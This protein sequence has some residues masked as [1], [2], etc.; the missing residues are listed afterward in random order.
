MATNWHIYAESQFPWE[1]SALNYVR[2]RLPSHS[3]WQAWSNF[4]FV[5]DDGKLYE[6]DLMVFSP[7]GWFLIEIKSWPGVLRGDEP[8]DWRLRRESGEERSVD[9][10]L[11]LLNTKAKKLKSLLE[12]RRTPSERAKP[13][14]FL[15][16]LVFLSHDNLTSQLSPRAGAGV[17]LRNNVMSALSNRSTPGLTPNPDRSCNKPGLKLVSKLLQKA[18]VR[19]SASHRKVG[20]YELKQLLREGPGWQDFALS[21]PK[22]KGGKPR[23]ARVYN[24]IQEEDTQVRERLE[25]AA[26]REFRLLDGF[27]HPGVQRLVD[28]SHQGELGPALIFEH[29]PDATTL[30]DWWRR[31]AS[32]AGGLTDELRLDVLRQLAEAVQYAHGRQ[33][34]HRSLS[35]YSVL[36]QESRSGTPRTVIRDWQTGSRRSASASMTRSAGGTLAPTL[37]AV[38]LSEDLA[39]AYLAPELAIE[40]NRADPALEGQGVAQDIFALGAI[41]FELFAGE[42]PA[43]SHD[44][45]IRRLQEHRGLSVAAVKDGVPS[46]IEEL[47]SLAT[48]PAISSRY[49][50][51]DGFL[52]Q[53]NAIEEHL[54]QPDNAWDGPPGEAPPDSYLSPHGLRVL[55]RLG[56]GSNAI[57]LLV[58]RDGGVKGSKNEEFVLKVAR[59]ADRKHNDRI[60]AETEVLGAL[61]SPYFVR[62]RE[63]M[64]LGGYHAV[65][66]DRAGERS[67]LEDIRRGAFSPDQLQILGTDLIAALAALEDAG[68]AHRDIKPENIGVGSTGPLRRRQLVLYDF[69]LSR[70][71]PL[72]LKAGTPGFIDPFLKQRPNP[73]WDLHAER[74]AAAVTLYQMATGGAFPSWGDGSLPELLPADVVAPTLQTD[75]FDPS[76]RD[77]LADFFSRAF[78]RHPADRFDNAATM[79]TAWTQAFAGT[80]TDHSAPSTA[81]RAK[82]LAQATFDSA[83]VDLGLGPSADAAFDRNHVFTVADFLRVNR[84]RLNRWRGVTAATRNDLVAAHDQLRQ[85]LGEAPAADLSES[86]TSGDLNDAPPWS[87]VL[88]AFFNDR[89]TQ[90]SEKPRLAL[91][92]LFGLTQTDPAANPDAPWPSQPE[93]AAHAGVT[94][95]R[96][97]QVLN[98]AISRWNK[99]A[100]TDALQQE[101]FDVLAT[102][103]GVLTG[104][105]LTD[106]LSERLGGES[107]PQAFAA[108]RAIA[109]VAVETEKSAESPRFLA[110]RSQDRLVI[111]VN[112]SSA[113]L[114][115]TLGTLADNLIDGLREDDTMPGFAVAAA[116][117]REGANTKSPG[118]FNDV[119]IPDDRLV[120][121]AAAVSTKAA[122]SARRELYPVGLAAER[123]VRL[124]AGALLGGKELEP[125]QL[126]NRLRSRYPHAQALPPDDHDLNALISRANVPWRLVQTETGPRFINATPG[127][128]SL[129]SRTPTTTR[130]ST[131]THGSRG[132]DRGATPPPPITRPPSLPSDAQDAVDFEA[133]LHHLTRRGGTLYLT[134]PKTEYL[135]AFAELQR[136]EPAMLDLEALLVNQLGL[137]D[138]P[139]NPSPT[140]ADPNAPTPA[141]ILAADAA[142]PAGPHWNNL[143]RHIADRIIPAIH[144]AVRDAS[145]PQSDAPRPVLITNPHW[146][147]RYGQTQLIGQLRQAVVDREIFGL[148]LLLPQSATAP[149]LGPGHSLPVIVPAEADR[150]PTAWIRN[151]HR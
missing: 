93:A 132:S 17:V 16:P 121:L 1:A 73:R 25:R 22:Q 92:A 80:T 142:G 18:G 108:V 126:R 96:V 6:I 102:A 130:Q 32:H 85:R 94:R 76:V 79:A 140:P 23:L 49:E 15:I 135:R 125:S 101:V 82:R 27:Q 134:V 127:V 48:D 106:R 123:A 39:R 110:R 69:S 72:N 47:V 91:R 138:T 68:L 60:D 84:W 117:L 149:E 133:K 9:N 36:I 42:R 128:L 83:V 98:E 8:T 86:T 65:L 111:A 66:M 118:I 5:A 4:E 14:P 2:Q 52:D 141:Q 107:S 31:R 11:F 104:R 70:E 89:A 19:P 109:R 28:I 116:Y 77:T 129:E 136:F 24:V 148:W 115:F 143:C 95:G 46:P 71:D 56:S 131:L 51:V 63:A 112:E 21:N 59:E 122:L 75:L 30:A 100:E 20:E 144:Q 113:R 145:N 88:Q 67:L 87:A 90:R 38:E 124:A 147:A 61:K 78:A 62:V 44:G 103:N 34:Y 99:L 97:S 13:L 29:L 120:K 139:D 3:P 151:L 40:Q 53:L 105:E 33:I 45:L 50:T 26:E 146:L 81:D 37:H 35:P 43:E 41:A 114:A 150:P 137:Q 119:K 58:Q 7:V 57:A 54:T 74:Y 10:P 12:R 64:N 55:R